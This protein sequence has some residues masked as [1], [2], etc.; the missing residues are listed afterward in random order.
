MS[1]LSDKVL[2]FRYF[3]Q[4]AL[5]RMSCR[6]LSGWFFIKKNVRSACNR[7]TPLFPEISMAGGDE[8]P[9][10]CQNP[11]FLGFPA[12]CGQPRWFCSWTHDGEIHGKSENTANT[13]KC[14]ELCP[15]RTPFWY[16][17][18]TFGHSDELPANF[19]VIFY[20][21]IFVAGTFQK[22]R[23]FGDQII[24]FLQNVRW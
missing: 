18:W 6:R 17:W 8:R 1:Q 16:F 19:A 10:I 14:W 7:K 5:I 11:R 15:K 2:I 4:L 3:G 13:G 9:L 23:C 22:P 21:K 12:H 20:K 24:L